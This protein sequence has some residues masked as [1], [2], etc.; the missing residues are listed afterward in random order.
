M[1]AN[2]SSPDE[3][4]ISRKLDVNSGGNVSKDLLE[5]FYEIQ[6]CIEWIQKHDYKKVCFDMNIH[7]VF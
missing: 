1:T 5:E 6:D 4:V 2:F 7:E 3:D